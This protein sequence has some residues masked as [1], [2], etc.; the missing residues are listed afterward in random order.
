MS[1]MKKVSMVKNVIMMK[2]S[3]HDEKRELSMIKNVKMIKK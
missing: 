1:V 3:Q 2:K